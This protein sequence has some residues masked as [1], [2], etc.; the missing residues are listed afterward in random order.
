MALTPCSLSMTRRKWLTGGEPRICNSQ[1]LLPRKP[2][3]YYREFTVNTPGTADR[4][5]R[6]IMRG[7]SGETSDTEDHYRSFI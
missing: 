3:G 2:E 6:R 7:Q 5:A 1:G 4:G